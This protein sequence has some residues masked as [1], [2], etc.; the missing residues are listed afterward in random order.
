MTLKQSVKTAVRGLTA[1]TS[2]S[3]LTILGIVIGITA[4][5]LIVSV[6]QGAENLILREISG[7]GAE[8]IVIRPGREPKGPSDIA[9]TLFSDSL[10]RRDV[11]ALKRKDNVPALVDIAPAVIVPG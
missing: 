11:E 3:I 1:H 9:G 5:M 10:K 7:M 6:G 2:R 4:I 8:T